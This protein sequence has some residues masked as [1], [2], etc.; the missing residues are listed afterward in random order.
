MDR[1]FFH[2]NS[3]CGYEVSYTVCVEVPE[4]SV[5]EALVK[6]YLEQNLLLS[7]GITIVHPDDMYNKKTGR[8]KS[9]KNIQSMLFFLDE[10]QY[11]DD[12]GTL[13]VFSSNVS[14]GISEVHFLLKPKAKRAYLINAV[15]AESYK[16]ERDWE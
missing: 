3:D 14:N 8:E 13:L 10:V 15:Y 12:V 6:P 2:K 4:K 5:F 7:C 11:L 16:K 9:S 1:Q